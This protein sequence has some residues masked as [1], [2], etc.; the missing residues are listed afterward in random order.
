MTPIVHAIVGCG[1]I[2]PHHA[3]AFL[4]LG[5]T[6]IA[7]AVDLHPGRART[8][9][10][11]YAVE[12]VT[13]SYEQVLADPAVTSISLCVPHDLHAPMALAGVDAGK[14][15]LVEKPVALKGYEVDAIAAAAAAKG[16]IVAPVAQHRFDTVVA[17]IGRLIAEDQL[18][19]IG[20]VRGH[21]ECV[22]P[23]EYY[24]ESDWRGSWLREGGS[25]LINQAYHIVELICWLAGPVT[26][27]QALMA[28]IRNP[29]HMETEDTLVSTL[30]FASGAV[31]A[32][33]VTGAGGSV[34]RSYIELLG[35]K[36]EIAFDINFPNVVHRF[37]LDDKRA[38]QGWRRRFEATRQSPSSGPG[39]GYYGH[40]HRGQAEAFVGQIRG[41]PDARA[42]SLE[43]ARDVIGLIE[44]VYASAR[45]S[46]Q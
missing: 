10:E 18:G 45:V 20:L 16:V 17:E 11:S 37:Q 8:L 34:W 3:D 19:R 12:T 46:R 29:E 31:G 7:Y 27:A 28:T 5:G 4:R 41:L 30:A 2:A 1:R 36:G 24:A 6:R 32:L 21:L 26:D 35:T 14:H 42:A 9:A 44:T 22:R 23:V 39:V 38:M 33:T 43:H 40:G 25:V 13:S 15:V